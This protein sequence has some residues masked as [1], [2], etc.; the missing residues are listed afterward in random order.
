MRVSVI[1]AVFNCSYFIEDCIRSIISQEYRDI[2]YILIDGGSTDGTLEIIGKYSKHISC[3]RSE[4][5]LSMYDAINKAIGL[6]TGEV[7]GVLNADD[8]LADPDVL[9]AVVNCFRRN[10]CDAVY[11]NLYFVK[12]NDLT[13]IVR[14]WKSGSFRKSDFRFGW[15]PPHPTLYLKRAVFKNCGEY[16]LSF[17]NSG[18][19]EMILRLFYKNDVS[20]FFLDRVMVIMRTGGR[21]ND[22]L[23]RICST[24]FHDYRAMKLNSVF[25][26]VIGVILKKLRKLRQFRYV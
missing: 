14:I 9:S 13:Q 11:G 23:L 4:P 7:I 24:A 26:P 10:S 20:A 25:N 18:D 2:E 3:M 8:L 19:Y 21:S 16:S 6:A 15:M 22:S 17:G 5:D 12:R 1:T